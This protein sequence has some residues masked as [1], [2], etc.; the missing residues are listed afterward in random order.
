MK[1][2]DETNIEGLLD[3]ELSLDAQVNVIN[4]ILNNVL[5]EGAVRARTVRFK[6]QKYIGSPNICERIYALNVIA[7]DGKGIK[8]VPNEEELRGVLED[9][10]YYISE[11]I[12]RKYVQNK[13][14]TQVEKALQERQ[15]KFMDDIKL[16]IIKKQKGPESSK[17]TK[18]LEKL[19]ELD[20]KKI[21]KNV[22][23]LLR[24][25]TFDEI[26]GQER[27]IKSLISKMSSPYPQHIILYGPPGIGKTSAARLALEEAKKL[28]FTPFDDDS[29]FVE[30]DGTTLRWDPREITNPLLGS[31]HDPIYQGSKKDL[32]EVGVPEPKT[33]LV[34]EAHGGVLFI[35]EIGELDEI[36]QNKLLKVLEDKRVEYSSSY[37]DPD[38]E[39]TPE[40]VKYLFEKGAPADFVLIGATTREPGR[41]NPA[42]RSRCTEVYFEPLSAT[43]IIGIIENASKKLDVTLEDGVA[44][45][46]SRYTIEGRKAVNILA[47]A[48]GYSL[49]NAKKEENNIITLKDVEEVISIGRYVPYE[50]IDEVESYE[51]GH[52]YGLGVSGFLGS[53]LEIEAVAFESKKP[54]MG[55]IKFNDTAGSMAKDS[56]FNAASVIRKLTDKD[57]KD[58]DIHVNVVGGGRI[59]GPS[60]GAAIT[61]AIVSALLEKP[62]RQDVAITGEIS[63]R[64]NIKPVGGIFEKI[65]GARRKGIKLVVVPKANEKEVP[66]DLNDIEVKSISRIEELMDIV[67]EK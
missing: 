23:S 46:I 29:K 4:Q 48:Y 32:A 19:E 44:E 24:P 54:G 61:I 57:I 8:T 42:L 9:T 18:K 53:T 3:S 30:V 49:Y 60:A 39:N 67:F 45:F 25:E 2:Y 26:I 64:G 66:S 14:E 47:D 16:S 43:D 28:N 52:T 15:D 37:Y 58:Y 7:S 10:I 1:T 35:D 51:V 31:V 5:D 38:D 13:V 20:A 65:Y 50:T 33:G 6:L 63:L 11:N 34:T 55:I 62:I 17:T 12:A 22:M 59:D 41:I 56:V 36:L 40:Y 27:A 21:N